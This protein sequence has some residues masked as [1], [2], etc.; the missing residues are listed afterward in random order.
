M[1]SP[2]RRPEG[3]I[4]KLWTTRDTIRWSIGG[5]ASESI[6]QQNNP[7]ACNNLTACN[8]PEPLVHFGVFS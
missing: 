7:T 5:G 2:Y 4:T 3:F 1:R 6:C 8:A